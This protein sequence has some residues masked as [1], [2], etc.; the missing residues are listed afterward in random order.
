MND[1]KIYSLEEA[2]ALLPWLYEACKEAEAEVIDVQRQA[3]ERKEALSRIHEIIHHW[4][5]TVTKLGAIPKQPFT[6]DFNSGSDYFCWE[7]P[8]ENIL[9]RH[10]YHAGYA[11][12]HRIEEQT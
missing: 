3:V 2:R 10:D 1:E 9:Y 12:R 7:Y 11:G 5:E 8:E 4:A 6:I